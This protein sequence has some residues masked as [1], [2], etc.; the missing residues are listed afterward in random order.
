MSMAIYVMWHHCVATQP[1]SVVVESDLSNP[2]DLFEDDTVSGYRRVT[3]IALAVSL[4]F[5][6]VT[7]RVCV[8]R[9]I[10]SSKNSSL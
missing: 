1:V 6:C 8:E 10:A 4:P 2:V 9:Q 5:C 7:T 3:A